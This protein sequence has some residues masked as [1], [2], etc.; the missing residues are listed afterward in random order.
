MIVLVDTSVWAEYFRRRSR[1]SAEQL[2][3]LDELI[4]D[5]R[6]VIVHPIRAEIL[7]GQVKK[8]REAEVRAALS[9][10][11]SIDLDW[12][13]ADTWDEVA[14][15]AQEARQAGIPSAGLVDRM[16]VLAAEH[17]GATI[18][19][20]DEPLRGLAAGRGVALLSA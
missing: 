18:W 1:L 9:A 8:T 19:S 11:T 3:Q 5:D 17:A 10:L 6:V 14:R 2:T 15:C 13:D 4:G 20:L 16:I 12:N 7:S